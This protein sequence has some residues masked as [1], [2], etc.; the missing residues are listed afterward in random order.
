MITE[1]Q[2]EEPKTRG[3]KTPKHE[4][5]SRILK[6][7]SMIEEG[8]SRAAIIE[9]CCAEYSVS[10]ST[11]DRYIESANENLRAYYEPQVRR[12]AEIAKRRFEAIYLKAMEKGDLRT[13][14]AAQSQLSRMQG[15]VNDFI[16]K[17]HR[18]VVSDIEGLDE[19]PLIMMRR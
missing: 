2:A 17:R 7:V 12:S 8:Q 4:L 14:L 5:E 13:A 11:V 1:T 3:D 10:R 18:Y 6:V 15:L 9:Q 19:R 16:M